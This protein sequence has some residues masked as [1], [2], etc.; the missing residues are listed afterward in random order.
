RRG[1]CRSPA[2]RQEARLYARSSIFSPLNCNRFARSLMRCTRISNI[3]IYLV[4][5]LAAGVCDIALLQVHASAGRN[6]PL[7]RGAFQGSDHSLPKSAKRVLARPTASLRGKWEAEDFSS[8]P[9]NRLCCVLDVPP[10]PARRGA[11]PD[12]AAAPG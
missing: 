10:A 6:C 4:L 7:R 9:T 2:L 1:H 11:L 5:A 12:A 3:G 8:R